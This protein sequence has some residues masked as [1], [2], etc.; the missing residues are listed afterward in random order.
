LVAEL[1]AAFLCVDPELAL[2]PRQDHTPYISNWLEVLQNDSRPI[3]SA[4]A[5]AQKA[6][7]FIHKF[8]AETSRKSRNLAC[9]TSFALPGLFC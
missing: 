7:D 6:A 8:I 4:A 9:L 1:G 2:E 5:H 3:F